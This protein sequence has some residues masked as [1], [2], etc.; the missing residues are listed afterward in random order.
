MFSKIYAHKLSLP[1][2]VFN[3]VLQK[4]LLWLDKQAEK[5]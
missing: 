2:A 1:A 5:G 3:F 4:M